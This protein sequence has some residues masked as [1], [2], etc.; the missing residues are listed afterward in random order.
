MKNFLLKSSLIL[1]AWSAPVNCLDH[2]EREESVHSEKKPTGNLFLHSLRESGISRGDAKG[3]QTHYVSTPAPLEI[4]IDSD[5]G[6]V[7]SIEMT[8]FPGKR[9]SPFIFRESK[10]T[11]EIEFS[12]AKQR[13]K[14]GWVANPPNKLFFQ[15]DNIINVAKPFQGTLT[16]SLHFVVEKNAI[17]TPGEYSV[18]LTAVLTEN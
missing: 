12:L 15:G 10:G 16:R 9:G 3:W 5:H 4:T 11:A 18:D 17:R 6:F 2:F 14:T 13:T 8:N 7:V 1:I